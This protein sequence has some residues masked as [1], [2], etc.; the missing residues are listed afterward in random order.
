MFGDLDWP[1][2]TSRRSVRDSWVS[3]YDFFY[4]L[5]SAMLDVASNAVCLSTVLKVKLTAWL[6]LCTERWHNYWKFWTWTR[7]LR[8][9]L[10]WRRFMNSWLTSDHGKSLFSILSVIRYLLT[11]CMCDS[12]SFVTTVFN[13]DKFLWLH[14]SELVFF[15][16]P[17]HINP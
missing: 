13:V 4:L 5:S 1:I 10:R 17:S 15:L 14:F 12:P 9:K 16:L 2:N 11:Y 6:C 3:C 8:M 7:T